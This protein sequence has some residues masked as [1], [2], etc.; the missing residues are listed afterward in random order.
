MFANGTLG[1]QSERYRR[2]RTGER[3]TLVVA[4]TADRIV[5]LRDVAVVR[6]LLPASDYLEVAGAEHNLLL[7]HPAQ[8]AASLTP[9]ARQAGQDLQRRGP[10]LTAPQPPAPPTNP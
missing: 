9:S 2:L 3:A 6:K 10:D 5:P 8:V 1:D 7:T 4:G